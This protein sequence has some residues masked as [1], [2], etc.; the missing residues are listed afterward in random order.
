MLIKVIND[1]V[2]VTAISQRLKIRG[3]ELWN[4]IYRLYKMKTFYFAKVN[5]SFHVKVIDRQC[6]S[7]LRHF[8]HQH[9][10]PPVSLHGQLLWREFFYTVA[11]DTANF[12]KMEGNPVCKQIPW[13]TNEEY[14][15]A[16]KEVSVET[17]RD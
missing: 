17:S 16:W 14:L 6:L 4:I 5:V 3:Y 12:D 2:K 8:F 7:L 15:K 9:T 1:N 13:D 11:A 10:S